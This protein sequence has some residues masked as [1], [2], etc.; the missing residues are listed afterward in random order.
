MK[1]LLS[2][3]DFRDRL[4]DMLDNKMMHGKEKET[5]HGDEVRA[6][7]EAQAG[8]LLRAGL[9]VLELSGRDLEDMAK[10]GRWKKRS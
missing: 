4:L 6:H 1:G 3:E 7:D 5:Y 2:Y 9:G 10:R 8:K